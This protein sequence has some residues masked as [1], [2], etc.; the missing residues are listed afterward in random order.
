[1]RIDKKGSASIGRGLVKRCIFWPQMD[2]L[3]RLFAGG[4]MKTQRY[5]L[6]VT[7]FWN[8][9][10]LQRHLVEAMVFGCKPSLQCHTQ[11]SGIDRHVVAESVSLRPL[12]LDIL[13]PWHF[14][15]ERAL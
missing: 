11:L 2:N 7:I 10:A 12:I 13:A 1:M 15:S 6:A 3:L 4:C 8:D 9:V 5:P 14:F